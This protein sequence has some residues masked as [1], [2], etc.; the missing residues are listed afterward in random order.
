M[1]LLPKWSRSTSG[2]NSLSFSLPDSSRNSQH[3]KTL[4]ETDFNFSGCFL[5]RR[6]SELFELWWHRLCHWTWDHPRFWQ[7]GQVLYNYSGVLIA[8]PSCSVPKWKRP[9]VFHEIPQIGLL[10]FNAEGGG[11]SKKLPIAQR[12]QGIEY[13]DSFNTLSSKQ[14][15]QQSKTFWSNISLAGVH[16][17]F[18]VLTSWAGQGSCAYK[19]VC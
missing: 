3:S 4:V 10:A 2:M 15:L 12:T 8:H 13:F 11:G 14:K 18:D 9:M 16:F 1:V 17:S 19:C 7:C 6:P 5:W